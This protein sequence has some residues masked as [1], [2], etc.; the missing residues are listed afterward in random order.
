MYAI[1]QHEFGPPET[2]IYEERSDPIAGEGQVRI[3]VRAAGVH[4]LDTKIRAGESGGPFPLPDLPMTPGREVAGVIDQVGAGV[5]PSWLGKRAVAHLGQASGGYAELAV[6]EAGFVHAIPEVLPFE[7]AVAAIGTGRTAQ[8]ILDVAQLQADDAVLVTAAAGGIGSLLVQ[9]SRTAG[10]FTIGLAGGDGKVA[11]V[12]ALGADAGV[13][14]TQDAWPNAVREALGDRKL[15][16]VFDGVGGKVGPAAMRLLSPGGRILLF[17]WSAGEPTQ[18]TTAD[19]YGG[20]LTA[21]A[22]IGPRLLSHPGG[23]RVFEDAA[24]AAAADGSLVPLVDEPFALADAGAAHAAL[25]SRGTV[26]KVVLKP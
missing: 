15:T 23:L 12:R 13:D 24:L 25:E 3:G 6:R 21:S 14:Y 1:R 5:D 7:A 19:L 10:A 4:L 16:V 9:A 20:G 2:L 11:R 26:G 18:I 17:G 22:A 8:G